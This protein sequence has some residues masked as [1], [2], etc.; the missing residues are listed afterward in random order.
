MKSLFFRMRL[1]HWVGVAL[2]LLNAT[3]FTD[4]PIGMAVQYVIALVVFVHDIDEKKWGV[5]ALRE[6]TDYMANFTA[7]D[8]SRECQVNAK[9]NAEIQHVLEVVDTFR[10][11]I[12]AA[13]EDVKYASSENERVAAGLSETSRQIGLRI[14]EESQVAEQ[15]SL[16]AEAISEMVVD[17]AR[18]AEATRQDMELAT[19]K[20]EQTRREV[21]QM[22]AAVQQSVESEAELAAKLDELSN[23]A[24]QIRK[25]L[26]EVAGIAD[27]TNLLALNAAIEAARAG[28]QG[29]G[30]AVVAD[31]VRGLAERTQ[32]S[33]TE[34]NATINTMIQSVDAT[35]REMERQSSALKELSQASAS[36]ESII[37]D[38][39]GLIVKS[40]GLAEK[41]ASVS[42]GVQGNIQGIVG[43]IRQ[44]SDFS[45]SNAGS[46]E[47]IVSIAGRMLETTQSVNLKL[48]QFKT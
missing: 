3:F 19:E 45:H 29:R 20:L 48:G 9:F 28:E 24:E 39:A 15:T 43:Q 25:V 16:N 41:T 47:E 30:F 17:L 46:V 37:N 38:T 11:N 42:S 35:G 12:R 27:Q 36:V 13:L 26:T 33:L 2:L 8:L 10:H 32:R 21:H 40:A 23:N 18:E 4:N 7:K 1:V 14:E 44:I 5:N 31:E 34:I 6:V 22:S